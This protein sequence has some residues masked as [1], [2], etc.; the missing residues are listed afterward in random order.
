MKCLALFSWKIRKKNNNNIINLSSAEPAQR[1]LTQRAHDLHTTSHQCRCNVMTL[2][3]RWLD[4]VS[5]LRARREWFNVMM[6]HRGWLDI[7][8][9]LC[10]RWEWFNVMM[11]HRRWGDVVLTSCACWAVIEVPVFRI[12]SV[13][14]EMSEWHDESEGSVNSKGPGQLLCGCSL[15]RIFTTQRISWI[16]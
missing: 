7:V 14:R 15:F 9:T 5:T 16:L 4:V 11:L 3:R 12:Y 10:V 1:V 8:S 2:H 6:L 13:P